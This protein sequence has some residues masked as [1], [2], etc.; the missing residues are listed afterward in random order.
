MTVV[1]VALEQLDVVA[2]RSERNRAVACGRTQVAFEAG[3]NIVVLPELTISGYVTDAADANAVAEAVDGPSASA[4]GELASRHHGLV[5]YGF[6]ERAAGKLFN[7]VAVVGPEG[8]LLHYRKLHLFD[9]EKIAY[10]PGDLGLPIVE[11]EF[12]TIGVCICYDLRFVE[13]MRSLSLR[14]ADIVLA[15]AA[16]VG[17]FDKSVPAT[18][19]TGHVDAIRAQANLD[20]V[21]VVAVSQVAGAS[22]DGPAT[23]GGSA[24]FDAYGT[25][26]A[27]PLSRTSADSALARIDLAEGRAARV[28]GELIRPR[29]DRRTDVYGLSYNHQPQ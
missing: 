7:S 29:E 3:A 9:R 4:L 27:G 10:T 24:G 6:C 19:A 1:N 17:G 14:G 15:P 26:L 8:L 16:W 13:V 23:L 5:A 20:Q 21:A 25:L 28:R 11:T 12:G 2:G 18:G 22:H